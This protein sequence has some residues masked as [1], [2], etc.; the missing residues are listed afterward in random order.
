MKLLKAS[1]LKGTLTV[2]GDKSISHRSIMLG[3]IA[4][5][6]TKVTGFLESADCLST[7]AC[8]KKLGIDIEHQNDEV[9]IH[10]KGLHGLKA[11]SEILDAGNSG[12]TTRLI[13]GILAAQPF[14]TILIGD[15]SIQKRPMN[16]I[17]TPLTMMGAHIESNHGCAPLHITG[18]KLSGITYT[19][20]VASAQVKS[21][22]LL[23]GLYADNRH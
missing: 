2:P 20:P 17:I 1:S 11:P 7:I 18:S 12:T 4:D 9:L 22:L 14:K 19:S 6:T 10:G 8:F 21:A 15:A 13:S 5:G 16:R 3:A 23:A